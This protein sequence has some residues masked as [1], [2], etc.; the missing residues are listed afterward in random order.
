MKRQIWKGDLVELFDISR[1]NVMDMT[2]VSQEDKEFLRSQREDRM[3]SSMRG[4][5][6]V[7]SS[8]IRTKFAK[9]EKNIHIRINIARLTLRSIRQLYWKTHVHHHKHLVTKKPS[10]RLQQRKNYVHVLD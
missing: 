6:K 1:Q 10:F 5:D 7:F 8:K 3:S 2:S 9:E 4:V